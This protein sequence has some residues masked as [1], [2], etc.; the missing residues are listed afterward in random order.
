MKT[1][2]SSILLIFLLF[3]CKNDHLLTFESFNY[4]NNSCKNCPKIEIKIPKALDQDVIS[5][6]INTA[7]K[8]EII[9]SLSFD[10]SIPVTSV[11]T[12]IQSFNKG[13]TDLKKMFPN[14]NTP[15]E[16][17]IN[18]D[19][20]YEDKNIISIQLQTYL[21]TG[22]A[23][24]NSFT[25]FLNFDKRKGIELE[26]DELI[27]DIEK[28]KKIAETKFRKQE[29]IPLDKNINSSGF[30]FENDEFHL[31]ENIGYTKE[32]LLLY[33][34]QYEIASYADGT[35]TLIFPFQQIK[36]SLAIPKQP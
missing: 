28:F 14:E 30:M 10:D 5:K 27:K 9:S 12:A 1:I 32:G 31:A 11:E 35:I 26:N 21:F 3:S 20:T 36:N 19:V 4:D 15:W 24:G 22:G 18:A 25:R 8:E 17:K 16:A 7:L 29:K 33:Y 6:A 13:Y 23:H 34:N 2:Y